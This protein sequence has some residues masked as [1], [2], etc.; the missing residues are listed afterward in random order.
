MK[1]ATAGERIA[2][3]QFATTVLS[4]RSG[5]WNAPRKLAAL[6]DRERAKVAEDVLAIVGRHVAEGELYCIESEV[7][8][9]YGG[10]G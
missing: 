3:K 4:L 5:A 9:K 1:K 10:K 7:R 6:I 2:A 8:A